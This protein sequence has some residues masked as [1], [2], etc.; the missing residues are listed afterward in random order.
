MGIHVGRLVPAL[1]VDGFRA[2]A[3]TTQRGVMLHA[4]TGAV[5]VHGKG[6]E[7]GGRVG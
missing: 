4:V 1:E 6:G 3:V 2:L 5:L 7:V